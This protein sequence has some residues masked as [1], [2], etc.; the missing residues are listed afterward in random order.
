[1]ITLKRLAIYLVTFLVTVTVVICV[2]DWKK[3]DQYLVEKANL[4]SSQG[5]FLYKDLVLIQL[6]R[7]IGG[8]EG[9]NLTCFRQ[10]TV[11][12][13]NTIAQEAENGS[14]RA[15]HDA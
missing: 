5:D 4:Q 13:L 7:Q 14:S 1:M 6:S 10:H 12:L 3:M 2:A 8:S 11:K 15:S 9:A